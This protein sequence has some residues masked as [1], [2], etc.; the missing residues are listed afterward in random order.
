MLIY[1]NRKLRIA[2]NYSAALLFIMFG[3]SCTPKDAKV[4]SKTHVI[5]EPLELKVA[6]GNFNFNEQ[7]QVIV[8]SNNKEVEQVANYFVEQFNIASGRSLKLEN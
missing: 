7:T 8:A 5:P 3:M 2:L 6:K 4:A 1:K